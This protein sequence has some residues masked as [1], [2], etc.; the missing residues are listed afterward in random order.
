VAP[1]ADEER[2]VEQAL[3]IEIPT[4]EEAG[5]IQASDRLV[6]AGGTLYM[7][8]IVP[9]APGA[10]PATIPITFV[11]TGALLITVR[12]GT[13]E[14]LDPVIARCCSGE[15]PIVGAGDLFAYLLEITVD[16]ISERLER[17]R[18]ALDHL[19]RG[20]FHHS[21]AVAQRAGRRLPI[22]KRTRRLEAVIEG[23]GTQYELASRLRESLQSLLRLAVFFNEHADS[24]LQR[25]LEAIEVDLRAVAD[26][27]S[28]LTNDMEFM[29]N[30]TTGLID[31]Q[32]NKVIYILSIVGV[33]L[34]PPVVVASIYGKNFEHIPELRW[35][36]GYPLALGLMLLS[37]I[38]PYLIIKLRGWL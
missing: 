32:Q 8:A 38:L 3:G 27:D 34:S 25:R 10:K 16:R 36:F 23:L 12:Y 17:I 19:S 33:V 1:S 22:G 20:I 4:R 6:D 2:Q 7:S 31:I 35:L 37:A 13:V 29:L 9:A 14:S 30:A 5:G 28:T 15:I 11:R 21:T 18:E 24:D 26:Y